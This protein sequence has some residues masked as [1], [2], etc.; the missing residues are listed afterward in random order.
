MI[1]KCNI[2][3]TSTITKVHG[4]KKVSKVLSGKTL[5]GNILNVV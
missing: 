4:L 5:I 1:T 3:L 2:I